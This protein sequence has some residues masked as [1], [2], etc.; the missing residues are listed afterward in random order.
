M[1]DDAASCQSQIN[2]EE[3]MKLITCY[4]ICINQK[5]DIMDIRR[6]KKGL[7]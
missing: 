7:G 3:L 4:L 1:D 5:Y 2:F 6:L